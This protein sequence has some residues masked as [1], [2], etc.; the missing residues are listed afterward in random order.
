MIT[1]IFAV[2]FR[3][4]AAAAAILAP[5]EMKT[6][7]NHVRASRRYGFPTIIVDIYSC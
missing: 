4:A 6:F 1:I 2:H 7:K 5:A 3:G